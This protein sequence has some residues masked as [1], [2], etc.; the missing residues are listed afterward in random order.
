MVTVL[1]RHG[2]P[3][4]VGYS[5]HCTGERRAWAD[6][7][8]WRGSTHPVAYVANGSHAN[9]FA[10][11]EHPIAVS[12]IP[13]QAIAL[14]Q[15]QGLP[16]PTDHAHPGATAYGPAGLAGVTPTRVT[17]VSAS[18]PRWIRYDGIWGEVQVFHAPPPIGTVP[19]GFSPVS[20]PRTESWRHPFQTLF[21]WPLS[22]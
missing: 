10:A 18:S 16:L 8:R 19:Q 21:G 14:L 3:V 2:H 11:G 1:I 12:C 22:P 20:P 17:R 13:P 6:V 9:L 7:Q 4:E 15:Q 5:Q